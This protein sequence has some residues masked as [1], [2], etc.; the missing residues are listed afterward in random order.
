MNH[1]I[2]LSKPKIIFT[3]PSYLQKTIA[4]AQ[5][6]N[7]INHII[8]YDD[9]FKIDVI[10]SIERTN[11]LSFSKIMTSMDS[12]QVN[13]FK[14]PPQNMREC[15][16]LILCSSGT[17]GLPKGVEITHLNMFSGANQYM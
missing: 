3:A 13:Q 8:L 10:E 4:V 6:N 9:N 12:N 2:N 16:G 7:F 1:A 14:C 5:R 15:V 17:T 11:I